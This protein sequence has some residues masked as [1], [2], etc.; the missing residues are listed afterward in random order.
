MSPERTASP[1][2]PKVV[3]LPGL[4][5]S[6]A[7]FEPLR[8]AATGAFEL[9]PLSLP[10]RPVASYAALANEVA[11]MLPPEPF[12]LLAESFSGPLAVQLASR[13]PVSALIL[14]ATFV[15]SPVPRGLRG[16][17]GTRLLPA[18]PPTAA[19][20]TALTGG[21]WRVAKRVRA[22][23][24]A[25]PPGVVRSRIRATLEVDEREALAG[26]RCPV[27]NVRAT[28]DRLVPRASGLEIGELTGVAPHELDGPHLLLQIA[29]SAAV[30]VIAGW[31]G[32][33]ALPGAG[34][35]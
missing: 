14:C 25:L 9:R 22:E 27:L 26:L 4:H 16:V 5:G 17:A 31:L 21:D 8:S 2:L 30:H 20:A 34:T 15:T 23:L 18:V 7:L 3:A 1:E 24:S 35:R 11:P 10:A 32:N 29:P 19:I 28:R 6:A 13:A 12:V 33:P